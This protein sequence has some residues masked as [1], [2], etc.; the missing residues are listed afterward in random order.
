[1]NTIQ[2]FCT[3]YLDNTL[4]GVEVLQIQEIIRYQEMTRVP[5]APNV[6]IS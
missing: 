6:V 3:F 5:L 2:Q 4:F 1:M